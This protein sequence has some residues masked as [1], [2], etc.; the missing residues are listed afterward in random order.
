MLPRDI[1]YKQFSDSFSTSFFDRCWIDFGANLG[2]T[3]LPTW[4]QI[5]SKSLQEGSKSHANLHDFGNLLNGCFVDFWYQ[6][7]GQV[8]QKIDQPDQPDQLDSP[9]QPNQT[10]LG[11]YW[12]RISSPPDVQ[13]SFAFCSTRV[14]VEPR[15]ACLELK[16]ASYDCLPMVTD[17]LE[18]RCACFVRLHVLALG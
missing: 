15:C 8:D 10:E 9:D 11:H 3:C 4:P 6:V 7:E 16:C 17:C 5:P 18:P 14:C 13:C 1:F 12:F 2:P